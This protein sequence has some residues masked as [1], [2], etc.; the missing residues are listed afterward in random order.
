MIGSSAVARAAISY[1]IGQPAGHE[2]TTG[3]LAAACGRPASGLGRY[4]DSSVRSGALS[5]R[6][7]N[8][9]PL[10]SL[11]ASHRGATPTV[12]APSVF[13]YAAA[14]VAAPFSV[15]LSTD[16]RLRIERRGML[17]VEL[18]DEERRE[19]INVAVCGVA[20]PLRGE[21]PECI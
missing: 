4:L 6:L 10:W 21:P 17:V 16:G 8:G 13:A 19:L 18:S 20:P 11:G 3:E 14:M 1:L 15:A 9:N 7:V 5:R 2:A 12:A